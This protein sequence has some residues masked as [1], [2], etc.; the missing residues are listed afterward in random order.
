MIKQLTLAQL[1]SRLAANPAITLLEALP[2]KY[3]Q[4]GH[5]PGA[6][7]MPHDQV[8]QLASILVPDTSAEVVV[9]CASATC[10]NSHIAARILDQVGYG[11][12]SVFTGGKQAWSEAG[13]AFEPDV[14]AA[15]A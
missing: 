9:Y 14:Q 10:Q 7:H 13:L 8:R 5:L 2:E 15:A 12:V 3:Y 11:N 6:L 1:Q 4:G